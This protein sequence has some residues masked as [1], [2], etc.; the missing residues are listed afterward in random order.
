MRQCPRKPC[1]YGSDDVDAY[2]SHMNDHYRDEQVKAQEAMMRSLHEHAIKSGMAM[3]AASESLEHNIS[4]EEALE[5]YR[6]ALKAV[7]EQGAF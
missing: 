7:M 4:P 3:W 1:E 2:V 6:H 5:A